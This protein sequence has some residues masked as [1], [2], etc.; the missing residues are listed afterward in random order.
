MSSEGKYRQMVFFVDTCFG[1]SLAKNITAKGL[2]YFT[3]ANSVEPSF[4]AVYDP[5]IK[6]WLS[7][8]FTEDVLIAVQVDPGI[9][10][11]DLYTTTY[12]RVTG[13]HVKMLNTQNFGD[14]N[15]P[16]MKFLSP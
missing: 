3:E 15:V 8:A 10:F 13:S 16:V 14:L 4:G 7:D 12:E 6:Q 11:R 9:T 5:D 2:L 1:E